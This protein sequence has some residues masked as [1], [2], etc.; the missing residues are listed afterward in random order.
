MP[1]TNRPKRSAKSSVIWRKSL[2][3]ATLTLFV[4]NGMVK[5][6]KQGTVIQ[7]N[8][9]QGSDDSAALIVIDPLVSG[10]QSLAKQIKSAG[11]A[12]L[13]VDRGRAGLPQVTERL[14]SDQAG[15]EAVVL[16]TE[17]RA[18]E[19]LLGSDSINHAALLGSASLLRNWNIHLDADAE[20]LL[21][22]CEVAEGE[23]GAEFVERLAALTG[24][25]VAASTNLTGPE[26]LGGDT[27]LEWASASIKTDLRTIR[28]AMAT[29]PAVM[30]AND[31]SSAGTD[32]VVLGMN[33][34]PALADLNGAG[35]GENH[36]VT[37]NEVAN[38]THLSVTTTPDAVLSDPDN[39]TLSQM[40]FT[41]TGLLDGNS[42]VMRIGGTNFFLGTTYS[43]VEIGNFLV[44]YNHT[45]GLFS[46]LPDGTAVASVTSY[47]SLLR[48]I[49]YNNTTDNPTAGSRTFELVI[50]DAGP[51]DDGVDPLDSSPSFF[52]VNVVPTNDQPVISN[53]N[54]QVYMENTIN[55][56][57]ATIGT[58][59]TLMDVDSADYDGG[60]LTVTGLVTKQHVIS[61]PREVAAAAGAV[62]ISAVNVEY[63]DGSIW[64]VIGTHT[65]GIGTPFGITFNAS[66]N[67]ERVER[68]MQNLTFASISD[69]PITLRTFTFT[70][71]DGDDNAPL[72]RSVNFAVK[73]E[74]DAPVLA[75]TAG[76][77]YTEQGT[78]APF[79]TG[80]S[81]TDPDIPAN[82]FNSGLRV[83]SL[84]VAFDEYLTGDLIAV[85]N[86]GTG[87]SQIGVSGSNITFAGTTF[88]SLT[89]GSAADLVITFTSNAAT[90]SAVAA[91]MDA[92]RYS[93]SSDDPTLDAT[94]TI[95]AFTVILNDGGNVKH[96]DSTSTAL[97]ASL[98]GVVAISPVNDPPILTAGANLNYRI[99]DPATEIDTTITIEDLDDTHLS[100][101]TVTI[102]SGL[103]T[104]DL[105]AVSSQN[106]ISGSYNPSTGVLTLTG[107][108][109]I[110]Q[111]EAAL[112]RVTFLSTS[113]YPTQNSTSRTISWQVTDAGSDLAGSVSS[114]TVTSTI[115]LTRFNK[116]AEGTD[117]AIAVMMNGSYAFES[118]DFGFTDPNDSPPDL[119][120]R[121]RI[122]TLP[123]VG[124]GVL[125][126]NGN[127]VTAGSFVTVA[128]LDAGLLVY[129]PPVDENGF[130][131]TSFTFQVEDNGG[132]ANGGVNLDATPNTMLVHVGGIVP[133]TLCFVAPLEA[134]VS[135][136]LP[137]FGNATSG[138]NVVYTVLSGP[139]TINGNLLT[140][141]GAGDVVVR[142]SQPGDLTYRPAP[143]VDQTI[144]AV[145]LAIPLSVSDGWNLAYGA[146]VAS[147][148][149][150]VAMEL[151]GQ[152]AQHIAVTGYVTGAG[153]KRD[154]YVT[155]R[156][157]ATGVEVWSKTYD[158]SAGLDDEGA[159]VKFDSAGNVVVIGQ[160][161]N[162]S[163]NTDIV[164]LKFAA[165]D[166][167]Q[168]WQ[169]TFRG[170]DGTTDTG[171]DSVGSYDTVNR[172]L[173]GRKNLAIGPSDEVIVGGF[174]TNAT[175]GRDL[176]VIKYDSSGTKVWHNT[177]DG[178]G[179]IDFAN[180][181]AV[182]GVGNVYAAGGSRTGV[183]MSR[184]DGVTLKY[185]VNGNLVWT[186]RYD[187]GRPDEITSLMLDR[188]GNP[189]VSGYTQQ[190]TFNMFVVRYNQD[191]DPGAPLQTTILWESI[192]D[193]QAYQSSEA[194]W[195]MGMVFGRD[196][197]V[198]GTSYPLNGVF[199]G[200]TMRFKGTC[201]E[202]ARW[203]REY[204]D[205]SGGQDQM[206]AMGS[207]YFGSPVV[208]GYT[209]VAGGKFAIEIIKYDA[210]PGGLLWSKRYES[211]DGD[212]EPTAVAVDPSGNVF[213][214]GYT[215]A[216]G[217]ATQVLVQNYSPYSNPSR[218][219][220]TIAFANPGAQLAGTTLALAATTDSGLPL[221]YTVVSG[222]ATV[223]GNSLAL[224]GSGSVT[225]RAS[226]AGSGDYL[227]ATPVE[228]TFSVSKSVQTISFNLPAKIYQVNG[229]WESFPL[230]GISTSGLELTYE[231]VSGSATI[232]AGILQLSGAG[233][234]VVRASQIG[235]SSFDPAVSVDR[236]VTGE[237]LG[238][239]TILNDF[240]INWRDRSLLDVSD[241]TSL[242]TGEVVTVALG[243]T[244][245]DA[246]AGYVAGY[247]NGVNGRDLYLSKYSHDIVTSTAVQSWVQRVDGTANG[248]DEATAVL[249]DGNGDV[250][251]TGY[252]T[253]LA[254][255]RDVYVG[256]FNSSGS[257]LWDY[258]YNG[259]GN[260]T[261]MG[262][263]L[264]LEGTNF[265]IVGGRV[266]GAVTGNDFFAAKL[267]ASTGAV[268]W[269]TEHNRG[270]TV[271]DIPARVAVGSDGGVVLTGISGAGNS[272]DGL[273]IKLNGADGSL[274][275]SRIY[276]F[277][278]RPDGM[279]GVA[280]DG[281]NNVIVSGYSQGAN[282]DMYTAK[283]EADTGTTLWDKRYN[284]NFNSSDAAWDVIVDRQGNVLVTGTSYRAAGVR[285]GMTVKY[286]GLDGTVAWAKRPFDY[287]T[288][289]G[290]DENLSIALDGLG[291]LVVVGYTE[292]QAT[293]VDYYV[294]R[295]LNNGGITDGDAVGEATF[296][297][298]YLG[299]DKIYQVRMDP[300]G[301]IWLVGYTTTSRG[302]RRPLVVRLAPGPGQTP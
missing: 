6:S 191:V 302:E 243:L 72:P 254:G 93:S 10:W 203:D 236:T 17:G 170:S 291:N 40:R 130:A 211:A 298:Y 52:T 113:D 109:T 4:A 49:T 201:V 47:Q 247:V 282:F 8:E 24:L 167:T 271:S 209:Q 177:Y 115:N 184:L 77:S 176:V 23:V 289:T 36:G 269:E 286:S 140:F 9:R 232:N 208:V 76:L 181:V 299:D 265:V 166:G 137:L 5:E 295:H 103:T 81:V 171:A 159:A 216:A 267:S 205:V 96:E 250:V 123:E 274:R 280:L 25:R 256:K 139:G 241:S 28:Q 215:T 34:G 239:Y 30:D 54:A 194:V 29:L 14:A 71:N 151:S 160:E 222:P 112:K 288:T 141:T 293:G 138:L 186:A 290:N 136:V 276:N 300:N 144:K 237:V 119:F 16:L 249:V 197:M 234:V 114:M 50:S 67:R 99:S 292:K 279:R 248:D 238:T 42:E 157:A 231:V 189:V 147:K 154:L 240:H 221:T 204:G 164:V 202:G 108:A 259:T 131:Y 85:A 187:N 268:V 13:V 196:V 153:G 281:A 33:N 173:K 19:L 121:V 224:Q 83:G 79:V 92:L 26:Q 69:N 225:V 179:G 261:D 258:T 106:G 32:D 207:D 152:V 70:L 162:A 107:T 117:G 37:W 86:L 91:L 20:L 78:A 212:S 190:N 178:A 12:V 11:Y 296:D 199:N 35:A 217:G 165:A 214:V 142:A 156:V 262:L 297:G 59:I 200:Y 111:Y 65:G 193:N 53:L 264:A 210:E 244:G 116:P 134:P 223:L 233:A 100:G 7:S 58:S 120:N 266:E 60:S 283:Y 185:D 126:L 255:G 220:Q 195:D 163:G 46:I 101:A 84:T 89:G 192:F 301:A 149:Q 168:L 198:T 183:A 155:K 284:G 31:E 3:L 104:G 51:A 41:L 175:A 158:G 124:K 110:P 82:F 15:Y 27:E 66:A 128:D 145:S 253:T 118:G 278:N 87:A 169:Q 218:T 230:A 226:Q 62:R 287:E 272:A 122:T 180:A 45:T 57:A 90:R 275:W 22:G 148:G 38:G 263:T 21:F 213:V 73:P 43:N 39:S 228:V 285:D 260:G 235:N 102:S 55:A 98:A 97:T 219:A 1:I 74:N 105:L 251:V 18:G 150:A 125:T 63:H 227:P 257:L 133:Q 56:I 64:N 61:L 132:T 245:N 174:V 206:V 44:S 270:S 146:G 188:D 80:S 135:Q 94:K 127:V 95:R 246:T 68:V 75:G 273:T 242:A 48:G 172:V 2:W 229:Q 143:T 88:A 129:T 252:V 294:A 161:T 182:D 277:A